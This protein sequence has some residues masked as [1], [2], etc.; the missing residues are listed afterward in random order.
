MPRQAMLIDMNRCVGCGACTIACQEE[1]GLPDGITRCWVEPIKPGAKPGELIYTHYVG[2]C[3][4]CEK[5]TCIEACPTGATYRDEKGRVRVDE[6]TCI[7]CGYCVDACPYG[8]RMLRKDVG[9]VDKCDLCA[10]RTD[11]GLQPACVETCPAGARFF[12][13]LDDRESPVSKYLLRH[14]VRRNETRKVAIGPR[15][16]YAGD[17]DVLDRI[18]TEHPPDPQRIVPPVQGAIMQKILRPFFFVFAGLALAGQG[19]AYLRQLTGKPDKD[20]AADESQRV[21]RREMPAVW[22]HW[23]NALVWFFEVITGFALLSTGGYRVTPGFFNEAV[24]AVFGSRGVLL[25]FHVTAGIVWTVVLLAYATFGYRNYLKPFLRSLVPRREDGAW[26]RTWAARALLRSN[27]ELPPQGKYN[28][29]QKLFGM[30]LCAGTA[31]VIAS[32]FIMYLMPASGW[33]VRWAIPVHFAAAAMVVIGLIVHLYMSLFVPSER[34]ALVSMFTGYVPESY[35]VSHHRL[36]LE[37]TADQ[38]ID[39]DK[40]PPGEKTKASPQGG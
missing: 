39:E 31:L 34:P 12:G 29:G 20:S 9:L 19:I 4:H 18:F 40:L 8:A 26:L 35:A 33:P 7:G 1:W 23:F 38:G 25:D 32:G 17:D 24:L 5:A 16:F 37:E 15:V 27:Q 11:A 21:K 13:D 30:V 14:N 10:A 2:M 28:A 22:L 6:E 3:N 36:W